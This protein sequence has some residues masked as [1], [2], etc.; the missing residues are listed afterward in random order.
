MTH[1]SPSMCTLPPSRIMG[2]GMRGMP[3]LCMEI[4]QELEHGKWTGPAMCTPTRALCPLQES[5][6]PGYDTLPSTRLVT[7]R[8]ADAIFTSLE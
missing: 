1:P 4:H 8:M 2:P 7:S 6:N 5:R 3:S